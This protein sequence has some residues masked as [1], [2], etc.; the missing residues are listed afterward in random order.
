MKSDNHEFIECQCCASWFQENK[1]LAERVKRLTEA[2]E[3][4]S[5]PEEDFD[6]AMFEEAMME[7]CGDTAR[8]AL[9]SEDG[10]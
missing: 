1:K 4:Y 10:P 6:L 3:F 5:R 2:L 7:D 8:K 9:E